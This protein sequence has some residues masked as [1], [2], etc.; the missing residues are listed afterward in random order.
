[1][2]PVPHAHGLKLNISEADNAMDLALARSVAPYLRLST[3]EAN[4][5]I[6]QQQFIS[7]W[8]T[9]AITLSFPIAQQRHFSTAFR[10]SEQEEGE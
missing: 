6:S 7:Q 8:R 4:E 9:T 1:M 10:L 3:S 2:N 5:I